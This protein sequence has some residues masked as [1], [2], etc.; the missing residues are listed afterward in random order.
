MYI[1]EVQ[2][3]QKLRKPRFYSPYLG[4]LQGSTVS[5][6]SIDMTRAASRNRY[7]A[8]QLGWGSQFNRIAEMLGFRDRSPD[9]ASFIQAVARWQTSQPGLSVDGIIG[10][11]TWKVMS[12]IV[13]PAPSAPATQ[14]PQPTQIS[15]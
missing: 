8:Q 3:G 4:A 7:Y 2:S 15:T 13:S 5:E 14:I 11:N 12:A 10:P 6:A 1:S 9:E